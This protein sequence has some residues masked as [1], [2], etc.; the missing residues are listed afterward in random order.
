MRVELIP[1]TGVHFGA[2]HRPLD[3][4][5][6]DSLAESMRVVGL[7]QPITVYTPD[8]ANVE[9]VAGAHRL[10]AAKRLG[11]EDIQA[12][13]IAGDEIDRELAE[14]SENLHRIDLTKEQR[15]QHIR[16]YAEL[17]KLREEERKK[18]IPSQGDPVLKRGPGQPK[19]IAT[20]VA[21]QTGLSKRTVNRVLN[22]K[23]NQP[24]RDPLIPRNDPDPDM[25]VV[26]DRLA[27]KHTAGELQELIDHLTD[28]IKER[29]RY[30]A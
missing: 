23:P 5:K 11:W 24:P 29:R 9:L 21:E 14:I 13:F 10:E 25:R 8:N 2:R 26:A 20:K 4:E 19:G 22:P 30:A 15:D 17:L 6:I 12:I 16:R 1:V 27:R 7:L 28:I 3:Q 18:A